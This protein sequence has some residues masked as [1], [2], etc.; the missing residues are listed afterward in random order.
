[1]GTLE[2]AISSCGLPLRGGLPVRAVLG[3]QLEQLSEIVRLRV[4]AMRGRVD[5]YSTR[6][7]VGIWSCCSGPRQRRPARECGMGTAAGLPLG[8]GGSTWL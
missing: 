5:P 7:R 2:W 4:G 1:V 6:L 8:V 3:E